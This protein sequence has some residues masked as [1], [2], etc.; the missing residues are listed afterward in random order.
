M[1]TELRLRYIYAGSRLIFVEQP[2]SDKYG[3]AHSDLVL[4]QI[5]VGFISPDSRFSGSSTGIKLG[6]ATETQTYEDPRFAEMQGKILTPHTTIG[7]AYTNRFGSVSEGIALN[8]TADPLNTESKLGEAQHK[9]TTPS[10]AEIINTRTRLADADKKI[11]IG[12]Q[13]EGIKT[14]AAKIGGSSTGAAFG[15]DN[16]AF[17][18]DSS[19]GG[20]A[21]DMTMPHM[22]DAYV[23][24]PTVEIPAGVYDPRTDISTFE[25]LRL[26]ISFSYIN[27]IEQQ[28]NATL[29][30]TKYV[31]VFQAWG[32]QIYFDSSPVGLE[33]GTF[34]FG[35]P[36]ITVTQ[37]ATATLEQSQIFNRYFQ[38]RSNP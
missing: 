17:K 35:C 37:P 5:L 10:T 29:I 13:N 32:W 6:S 14:P 20:S 22:A 11:L 3:I 31:F 27:D 36:S 25:A 21:T 18:G 9:L 2:D 15:Q 26:D 23:E 24:R 16:A 30:E 8:H 12:Q 1:A 38:L 19:I 7:Y 28:V 33:M 34:F 4:G